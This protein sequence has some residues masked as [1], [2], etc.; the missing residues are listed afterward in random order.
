VATAKAACAI[1]PLYFLAQ[2]CFNYSLLYTSVTN[3]S[4]LSTSSSVFT[5][6][7]SAWIVKSDHV[8]W[9][10]CVAVLVYVA[11]SVLGAFWSRRSPHD[12]VGV[13]HVDP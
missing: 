3:N 2:L 10:R 6:A 13:V 4:I 1:A 5:F 12:R 8:N 9:Q 7:L 11:G